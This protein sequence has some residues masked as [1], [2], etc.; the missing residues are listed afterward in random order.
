MTLASQRRQTL[1]QAHAPVTMYFHIRREMHQC[2][3][4]YYFFSD[5]VEASAGVIKPQNN[6]KQRLKNSQAKETNLK[7]KGKKEEQKTKG[8]SEGKLE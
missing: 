1:R 4:Y 8:R 3:S 2:H 6:R 7:N 5:R